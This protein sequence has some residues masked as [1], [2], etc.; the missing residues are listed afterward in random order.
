[1]GQD[2]EWY[3]LRMA[4]KR[5]YSVRLGD[6]GRLVLPSE[7]RAI[8]E[9]EP[10]DRF[11]A[12]L[13]HDGSVRLVGARAVARR[14]RGLLRDRVPGGRSLVDDLIAERRDEARRE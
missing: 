1:M 2:L 14:G 4:H 3:D 5:T 8:L 10:G 6:R 11:T 13:E 9:V 7:L 12:V